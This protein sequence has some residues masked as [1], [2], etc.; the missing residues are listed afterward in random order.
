MDSPRY[1]VE[2]A[3]VLRV[4]FKIAS[5]FQHSLKKTRCGA[6][7]RRPEAV[8]GGLDRRSPSGLG[9]YSDV[10]FAGFVADRVGSPRNI[11]AAKANRLYV[12]G[13][14]D[15]DDV[16]GDDAEAD[17]AVRS[18]V[19]LAAAVMRVLQT[20]FLNEARLDR[21]NVRLGIAERVRRC[22]DRVAPQDEIV[23]VRSGGAENELGSG[24]RFEF[25]RLVRRL[26]SREVPVPQFVRRQQHA[27]CDG[28]PEDGVS[29]RGLVTPALAGLQAYRE[30][31]DRRGRREGARCAPVAA[32]EDA[33]RTVLRHIFRGLVDT[34]SRAQFELRRQGDPKLEAARPLR[35]VE[36]AAVPHAASSLHPFDA[37]GR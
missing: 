17:P 5:Q 7:M 14:T 32:K 1:L 27:R 33:R 18:D 12:H 6:A 20:A 21:R 16:V 2:A 10:L 24:Q 19:A 28:D 34:Y 35:F 36:P 4:K 8:T 13:A 3:L 37:A 25:D 26:E 22:M 9:H 23:L 15:V 31:V 29:R 11:S 30:I